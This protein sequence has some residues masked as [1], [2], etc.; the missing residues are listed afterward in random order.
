MSTEDGYTHVPM[1]GGPGVYVDDPR[2]LAEVCARNARLDRE[3]AARAARST[4]DGEP[5]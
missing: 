5:A 2:W 3:D 1:A 4:E